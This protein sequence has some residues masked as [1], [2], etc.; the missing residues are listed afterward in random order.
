MNGFKYIRTQ[1]MNL[2]MDELA[3]KLG[4]SKQ[5]IYLWE[6]GRKKLPQTRL[7]EL[8]ALSGIPE[9]YFL[10]N[11]LSDI[12]ELEIKKYWIEKQLI[13][14]NKQLLALVKNK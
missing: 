9:K 8:S 3:L 10:I 4:I 11:E 14:I 6:S 13:E 5:A 1:I 7:K 12:D 2:T